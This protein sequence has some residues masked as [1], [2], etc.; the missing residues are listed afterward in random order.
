MNIVIKHVSS[1]P[2]KGVTPSSL[3]D[4]CLPEKSCLL[5]SGREAGN[6]F[7]AWNPLVAV[8][9]K[10]KSISVNA[11]DKSFSFTGN[12]FEIAGNIIKECCSSSGA[13]AYGYFSYEL[14]HH[15][16][17]LPASKNENPDYPD[18]FLIIP[19]FELRHKANSGDSV[20]HEFSSSLNSGACEENKL[21]NILQNRIKGSFGSGPVVPDMTEEYYLSAMGNIK[22]YI[23][24]GHIYQ[25][26]FAQRFSSD[27]EGKPS[28]LFRELFR[29]NPAPFFAYIDTG[30]IQILSTSPERF[31]KRNG[32]DVE[33]TPIKGTRPR[34]NSPEEDRR[35]REELLA[36]PKEDSELSMIVDLIRN[37]LGRVAIPG[38]IGIK[39]HKKIEAYTN[40]F[41]MMTTVSGR[42][43]NRVSN[44][45]I[46][47]ALFPCGSIT[48]CP[49]IRAM[50]I[51]DELE[52]VGRG[53]YT[54]AIGY[55]DHNQTM[56]LN[57]AIRTAVITGNRLYF[58]AGGGIVYE[59][60]A[61][62]EFQET[63][64]KCETFFRVLSSQS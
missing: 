6:S 15:I 22:E 18:L 58:S 21:E 61:L 49:K 2:I 7:F 13:R 39:D 57:V 62:K 56:D 45:D 23:R 53:I 12:P 33:S 27:F 50:E 51:I 48:G 37:D 1:K 17:P 16:E 35:E 64:F 29:N 3:L 46:L 20:L 42:I 47:N 32:N 9:A 40:V 28:I 4:C 41:Q 43:E 30:E 52:T 36:S 59:S 8:S 26:N 55:L 60:D 54:G 24:D 31:V 19:G 11:G 25:V 34:M 63:M 44:I 38:S 14:R 10:G 5:L